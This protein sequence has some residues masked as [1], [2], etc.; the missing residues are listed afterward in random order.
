MVQMRYARILV[1]PYVFVRTGCEIK[2]STDAL[3]VADRSG[4]WADA[5]AG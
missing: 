2:Q 3:V 1:V 4:E 5:G